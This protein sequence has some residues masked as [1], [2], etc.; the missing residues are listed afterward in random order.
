MA[1]TS[2]GGVPGVE[3]D[4][5]LIDPPVHGDVGEDGHAATVQGG[6]ALFAEGGNDEIGGNEV[7]E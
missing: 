5:E 6:N 7:R 1:A 4:I 3:Q 2:T